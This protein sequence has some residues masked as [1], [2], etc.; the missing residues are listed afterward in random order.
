MT[1]TT[2]TATKSGKA[3][4]KRETSDARIGSTEREQARRVIG[5]AP[6]PKGR[7]RAHTKPAVSREER[8]SEQVAKALYAALTAPGAPKAGTMGY[9]M[10]AT[11]LLKTLI[12]QA[13]QQGEDRGQLRSY[14]LN[15]IARI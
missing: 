14:A 8:E 6:A 7:K 10:G 4:I 9:I 13:E 2:K 5:K 12:D 11:T 15:L 1:T 3:A